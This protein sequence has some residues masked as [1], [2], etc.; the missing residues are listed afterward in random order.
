MKRYV[1]LRVLGTIPVLL[2]VTL[3]TFALSYFSS[4]D[5]ITAKY[6]NMGITPDPEI[7]AQEREEAGLNDSFFIQYTRWLGGA[8]R[9]IFGNSF[10]YGGDA[11]FELRKRLPNTLRLTGSALV[12][13]ILLSLPLGVICAVREGG[14][15]DRILRL[16][17]FL[18]TAMPSFWVAML[19]MY[20]FG[21]RLH[22]LPVM[23]DD[24]LRHLIL[25]CATL[26]FWLS[27]IYV[28]RIRAAALEELERDYV[29]GALS[30]GVKMRTVLARHVLPN[31]LLTQLS[32]FGVT[33]GKLLGGATVVET[34]FEWQG[35]GKMVIAAIG[36][37]DYPVI[38]AYVLW[39]AA[40]YALVQ[41][42]TDLLC[43]LLDPRIRLGGQAA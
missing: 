25:P 36:V 43:H 21:V 39:V 31:A 1:L 32:A 22:W 12:C 18:G 15:F 13:T 17:S 16:F 2:F 8:L 11:A 6:S 38:L 19:L 29:R 40:I 24:G 37:R 30:R 34:V 9:G 14:W 42:V 20:L 26:T 10:R 33:V 3:M 27:A 23:G 7:L 5:P 28:R 35:I 4:S 41:L